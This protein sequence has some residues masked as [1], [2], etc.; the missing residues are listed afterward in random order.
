M[1]T[2]LLKRLLTSGILG[3]IALTLSLNGYAAVKLE[4]EYKVANNALYFNGH[5]VGSNAEDN[6]TGVYD[7]KFGG[8]ISAHGDT[9]W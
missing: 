6:G 5:K 1:T 9:R 3:F 4:K 7:Y 8:R 2:T